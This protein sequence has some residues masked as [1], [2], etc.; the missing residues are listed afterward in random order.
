MSRDLNGKDLKVELDRLMEG[1]RTLD[2][3]K[4]MQ[5]A[6]DG[7]MEDGL[8]VLSLALRADPSEG[9]DH[10]QA[11]LFVRQCGSYEG[12]LSDHYL[13]AEVCKLALAVAGTP[14]AVAWAEWHRENE[15]K[16]QADSAA[17]KKR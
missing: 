6:A 4:R 11:R 8:I 9:G 15:K 1:G 5:R 14:P 16:R 2:E 17:P 12:D 13:L 3:A 7:R 10:W